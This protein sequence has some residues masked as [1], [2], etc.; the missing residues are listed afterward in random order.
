MKNIWQDLR[1]ALRVLGKAPGST[2]ISILLIAVGVAATTVI[3]S[4]INALLFRPL[5]VEDPATLVR[6]HEVQ[7][8]RAPG[9]GE[10]VRRVYSYPRYLDLRD[11]AVG[12][13]DL[14][15]AGH[16]RVSLRVGE[17]VEALY[18]LYASNNYFQVLGL[19]PARG[20]FFGSEPSVVISHHLWQSWFDGD[21][22]VV[23]RQVTING[24]PLTVAGVAPPEFGG[25]TVGFAYDLWIPL[26]IFPQLNPG[27][28]IHT[29]GRQSWLELEGR[30]APGVTAEQAAARLTPVLGAL[31]P[32]VASAPATT[33]VRVE[34]LTG[35]PA[36]FRGGVLGFTMLLQVTALLVLLIASANVAG[37]LLARASA[38]R[39]EIAVRLALGAGRGRLIRQLVTES[40]VLFLFGGGAGLL[41]A[42]WGTQLAALYRPPGAFRVALDIG[43]SPG[44]VGVALL[45]AFSTGICCGLAPA[46]Q[47]SRPELV[48]AL[49]EGTTGGDRRRSR[50]RSAFV[51]G[52]LAIT[53]VLLTTAGLF[54]RSLQETLASDP[55]FETRGV[56]AA[57]PD[58]ALNGY[59][60]E[61]GRALYAE[62]LEWARH[63]PGVES[64]TLAAAFPARLSF[65]TIHVETPGGDANSGG[66]DAHVEQNIVDT[67]YF[68]TLQIPLV[69][70]RDFQVTDR[71][72]APRVVI[73]NEILAQRFWP[74]GEALGRELRVAGQIGEVVGVVGASR[75]RNILDDELR[76]YLYLP[77]AQSYNSEMALV[78]RAPSAEAEIIAALR[79]ELRGL[80]PDLP[81]QT[82]DRLEAVI[83]VELFPQR[84][85]ALVI[86]AFGLTGLALAAFGIYG[87]LAFQVGQRTPEI[88]VRLALGGAAGEVVGLVL[89]Q[90]LALIGVGLGV[91]LVM[92]LAVSGLVTRFL[93][94]VGAGDLLTFVGVPAVL[95]AVAL[96]ASWIPARRAAAVDPMVALRAE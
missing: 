3:L 83:G 35:V 89:R 7:A 22:G 52:Q 36:E 55:G 46:L 29:P 91:G 28:D 13:I 45:I 84:L 34:P 58:P 47:A 85:A 8:S 19:S 43:L 49:K 41:L 23:G 95:A 69:A 96:L 20:R 6:V 33:G 44:I 42:A 74:D 87:V 26:G 37:V 61:R 79:R 73:V 48:S 51:V 70:G 76:P 4:A 57:E 81:L 32:E 78:A 18:G 75:N 14:A 11:A 64:A 59:S 63:N 5:P 60:E 65:L 88:G 9:A 38:R 27:T 93:Y 30:L 39:R 56:V 53:L 1:Y 31:G 62:L 25:T 66:R 21:P 50:L 24:Q 92:A 82:A 12:A 67:D 17:R 2:T 80:D 16:E 86:G 15:A 72:G 90:G 10:T 94:G 68:E 77:F 40:V 71:E 54:V